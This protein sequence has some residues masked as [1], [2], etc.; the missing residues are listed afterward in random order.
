MSMTD[1]ELLSI[2]IL[3]D[4]RL[5]R[6]IEENF[7]SGEPVNILIIGKYQVG[8]STLINS[9]FYKRG[10][11][12]KEHAKEGEGY[13]PTSCEVKPYLLELCPKVTLHLYDSPG[14]QDGSC[15]KDYLD[16][17]KKKCPKLHLI[18]FCTKINDSFRQDDK[19]AFY[20]FYST[21]GS[22]ALEN[23]AI[24]LT[25][26]D[27]LKPSNPDI[28]DVEFFEKKYNAKL[29]ELEKHFQ[30]LLTPDLAK[31]LKSRAFPTATACTERLP[32]CEYNYWQDDFFMRCIQVAGKE[33]ALQVAGKEKVLQVAGKEKALQVAGEEKALQ[34]AGE[35]KA[36]QK[37][38]RDYSMYTLVGVALLCIIFRNPAMV[39]T[40]M[41][42]LL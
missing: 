3:G 14:L 26:A 13:N 25:H 12:Y 1:E 15:D 31:M 10:E 20:N 19:K 36:L 8:K 37:D 29:D 22:S 6:A 42:L 27:Q 34:V 23:M 11:P 18:L 5:K 17:I 35:E 28:S 38:L 40:L 39:K 21:F 32:T 41:T 33:K 7:K 4:P 24:A 30:T 16:L 9:L 2:E